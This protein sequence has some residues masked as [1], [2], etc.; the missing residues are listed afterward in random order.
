MD[1]NTNECT[2][3]IYNFGQ[4]CLT[5]LASCM[6]IAYENYNITIII[7]SLITKFFCNYFTIIIL[8]F[9]VITRLLARII[10]IIITIID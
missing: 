10:I 8:N 2:Y 9:C 4:A 6:R 7:E 3:N 5:L 1:P